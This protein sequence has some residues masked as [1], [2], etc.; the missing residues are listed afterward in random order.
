MLKNSSTI[1][2]AAL[3]LQPVQ[4]GEREPALDVLRGFALFGVLIA[5]ALW[6]L[7]SPAEETYGPIDRALNWALLVLVDTKAYTIFAFLFGLGFSIQLTRARERGAGVVPIYYRRLLALL[8]IGLAHALL[9]R[10]GDILVPYAVMGFF[11]LLFRNASNKV[12]ALGAIIGLLFPYL[13]RGVWELTSI[14]FPQ[15]PDTEGMGYFASNYAWVRYWYATAITYWPASLPMFLCGLYAG[16]LRFFEDIAACRR[17]LRRVLVAGLCVGAVSFFSRRL[18]FLINPG[19]A[20]SFWG[21]LVVG[22]LWTAHSW[23]LAA[24]Y[25]SS[26]LLLWQRRS[27]QRWLAPLGAAGRMAL[28][29][30]LLQSVLIVPVCIAFGLFDRITPSLG[31]LLALSVWM[32]QVPASVWWLKRYRFGPAE[33]A[34]RSLTYRSLQPMRAAPGRRWSSML[35]AAQ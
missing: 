4:A 5:Y 21:R 9:L 26:L 15:R 19:W 29:N 32:I 2:N 13:A 10:N 18:L 20:P 35:R 14:P 8:I 6:N 16:R 31:L 23:G 7:G 30:Y 1:R 12:L 27:W 33:W 3:T 34:W 11:L 17:A 25:A 22:L 24:F 28:T